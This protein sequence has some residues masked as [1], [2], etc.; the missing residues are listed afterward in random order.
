MQLKP[1][2]NSTITSRLP[3]DVEMIDVTVRVP[4]SMVFEVRGADGAI[5]R[6][7]PFDLSVVHPANLGRA[8]VHGMNQRIPDSAAIGLTDD[9]GNVIPR[10]ERDAMK[11]ERMAALIEFYETGTD[12]WSRIGGGGGNRSLTVEAIAR[13]KEITYE[14]ALVRVQRHADAV[15]GGNRRKALAELAKG[16]RVKAAMDEIRG[17]RKSAPDVDADKLLDQLPE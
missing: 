11:G 8:L 13:V 15:C 7:L 12:Q 3:D 6:A 4:A 14:E 5:I 10:T 9:E 17:E 1:K 2:V 16:E